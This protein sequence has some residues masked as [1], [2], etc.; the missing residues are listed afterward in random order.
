MTYDKPEIHEIGVAEDV[1]QGV[2][3]D[4]SDNGILFPTA[5]SFEEFDE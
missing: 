1:I 3:G 5:L 4:G 2:E